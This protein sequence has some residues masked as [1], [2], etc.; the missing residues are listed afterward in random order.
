[1]N[2]AVCFTSNLLSALTGQDFL[3]CL[4]NHVPMCNSCVATL[5]SACQ[6]GSGVLGS[7]CQVAL[8][9][10][11]T[12]A[13]ATCFLSN[14]LSNIVGNSLVTCLNQAL[15]YCS[16]SGLT[17]IT[18]TSGAVAYTSTV[19]SVGPINLLNPLATRLTTTYVLVNVP[20]PLSTSFTTTVGGS[21][22]TRTVTSTH[23]GNILIPGYTTTYVLVGVHG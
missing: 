2:A 14:V 6:A 20:T 21:A 13:A 23:A 3:S 9:A 1:V 18:Q 15:P 5:P 8:G 19:T 4:Q 17:T 10:F 11:G 22:Y 7:V 16:S 12:T